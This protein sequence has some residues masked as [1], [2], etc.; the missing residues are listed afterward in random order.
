M[1]FNFSS[2]MSAA[3]EAAA[4]AKDVASAGAAAAKAGA[5][6]AMARA[7]EAAEGLGTREVVVVNGI[8]ISLLRILAEGGYGYVYL[9]SREDGRMLAVKK[10]LAQTAE[11]RDMFKAEIAIMKELN[12]HPNIVRLFADEQRPIE[13]G[14]R[15]SEFLLVMELCGGGTL[16]RHVIPKENVMPP[17]LGEE[18]ML[19]NMLDACKAIAHMHAQ[20]P[21]MIHRDLKLENIL[22]TEDGVCKLCDFGSTVRYVFDPATVDRKARLDEEDVITRFS[23]AMNRSPEMVDLAGNRGAIGT[24]S[25]VWAIGCMLFTLAFQKHPFGD[26]NLGIMNGR[27]YYPNSSPYSKKINTL[28]DSM[29]NTDPTKRPTVAAMCGQLGGA[30]V[31][32]PQRSAPAAPAPTPTAAARP[33][34]K[35]PEPDLFGGGDLMGGSGGNG[36]SGFDL[37]GGGGGGG[38][39]RGASGN[40]VDLLGSVLGGG[41]APASGGLASFGDPFGSAPAPASGGFA[42]FGDP[43]GSA[44]A[45]ASG[46]FAS[47]GD[48]FASAPAPAPGDFG[49][50]GNFG[51]PEPAAPE[52]PPPIAAAPPKSAADL[53]MEKMMGGI[54][55]GAGVNSTLAWFV[56]SRLLTIVPN[57][58]FKQYVLAPLWVDFYFREQA[59]HFELVPSRETAS[60]GSQLG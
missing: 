4:L 59:R 60:S 17:Q 42:S 58:Q 7:Q 48:P 45:P 11:A 13:G 50:F 15:G 54:S 46:G 2:A 43:F 30:P 36:A 32:V 31:A 47:F 23:T 27:Y 19:H 35:A 28:I 16:A 34:P 29:L 37:M 24:P 51:G 8:E 9:A 33:P 53:M 18:R 21:P 39:S 14:G 52:L 41:S 38:I 40:D 5:K 49:D 55:L 3:R 6:V 44:P 10:M 22:E 26:S 56:I 12:G 1:N 25:D 57:V 20:S